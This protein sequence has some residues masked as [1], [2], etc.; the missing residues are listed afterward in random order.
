MIFLMSIEILY[1]I[2][3]FFIDEFED[4]L[5]IIEGCEYFAN[6]FWGLWL[7]C[8]LVG[9]G[10]GFGVEVGLVFFVVELRRFRL[11]FIVFWRINMFF[12]DFF[13]G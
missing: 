12:N 7:F 8:E 1:I 11:L 9:V 3:I 4:G 6:W 10:V 13:G 2:E 5:G